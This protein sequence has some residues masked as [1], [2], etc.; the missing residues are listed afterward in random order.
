ML[1]IG[2]A[3]KRDNEGSRFWRQ[4]RVW[5][6]AIPLTDCVTLS[7]SLY[8]SEGLAISESQMNSQGY[9]EE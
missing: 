9:C 8:F 3:K 7:K 5:V 2:N 4:V 1:A 6:S